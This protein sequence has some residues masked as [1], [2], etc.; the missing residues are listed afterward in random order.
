MLTKADSTGT[1]NYTWDSENRLASVTL[2]GT[3]G[4]VSFKYDP[5]GRRVYKSSSSGT[6]VYA[7]DADNLVKEANA[8]GAAVVRYAQGLN[9]DEPLAIL[10]SGATSYYEAD[11]LGT[12]TSLSN[13]SG[14]L[15]NTY[16][17]DGFG[18][19]LAS[20]GSL[21]NNFRYTGREFDPETSLYYYRAR[22]YDSQTGRFN[23]EDPIGTSGGLNLYEYVLNN[24]V[25]WY[26]PRGLQGTKPKQNKPSPNA[27]FYICCRGGELRVC[28]Q[29]SGA[30]SGWVL[31]CMRQHEQQHVKDM[32][33]DGK[34]PCKGQ[35]DG[36]LQVPSSMK[37]QLECAAYRRELECMLPAPNTKEIQ[38]RRNYIKQQIAN[39][40]GSN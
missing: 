9:I 33:C 21:V 24:S 28:D 34:T 38:D 12:L 2:P 14:T 19:L 4:T 15:A 40:C 3:G 25:N 26:D 20:S 6:S 29:N 16:T 8:A 31:D 11:G 13:S 18:N 36:P 10:R 37:S 5:F 27:V 17:Y 7:Y 22:Y 35:P 39:Y 1:T 30:F 23:S 32:T